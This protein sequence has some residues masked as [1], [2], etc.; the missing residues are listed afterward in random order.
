MY[1]DESNIV[2]FGVGPT[3]NLN[4]ELVFWN[5]LYLYGGVWGPDEDGVEGTP[6]YIFY[7]DRDLPV[8][9]A[10]K[11]YVREGGEEIWA[12][13]AGPSFN[14]ND[15]AIVSYDGIIG[16]LGDENYSTEN[17]SQYPWQNTNW[18][19]LDEVEFDTTGMGVVKQDSTNT[20][21]VTGWDIVNV[22]GDSVDINGEYIKVSTSQFALKGFQVADTSSKIR[23]TSGNIWRIEVEDFD[24]VLFSSQPSETLPTVWE[25]TFNA[26]DPENNNNF[27]INTIGT[28]NGINV[29]QGLVTPILSFLQ[30][31]NLH[32]GVAE[33]LR[34]RNLGYF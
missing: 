24:I 10:R 7:A 15:L 29:I 16:R 27:I 11:M 3:L 34:L 13:F 9:E 23:I 8:D 12:L 33:F 1:M 4:E 25:V 30:V 19:P 2:I 32:G 6:Y 21:I 20:I 31:A 5:G 28:I 18:E 22:P 26:G 14:L 17:R